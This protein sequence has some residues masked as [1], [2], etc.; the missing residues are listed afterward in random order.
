MIYWASTPQNVKMIKSKEAEE[1][2]WLG[3]VTAEENQKRKRTLGKNFLRYS[4]QTK[5]FITIKVPTLF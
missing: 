4:E 1:Q 3:G 2:T 5:V